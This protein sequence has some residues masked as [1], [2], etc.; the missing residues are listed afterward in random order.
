M[1]MLVERLVQIV[2]R[3]A[4]EITDVGYFGMGVRSMSRSQRHMGTVN[5][6]IIIKGKASLVPVTVVRR[7]SGSGGSLKSGGVLIR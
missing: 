5:F 7:T 6:L 4:Y 3:V 2:V 1:I